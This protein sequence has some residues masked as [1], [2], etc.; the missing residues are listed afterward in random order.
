MVLIYQRPHAILALQLQNIKSIVRKDGP[1]LNGKNL[2]LERS[3]YGEFGPGTKRIKLVLTEYRVFTWIFL[4]DTAFVIFNN[5]PPRMVIKEMRMHMA[6][7]ETCF[8]AMTA[9]QCHQQIQFSLPT[10][11]LYWK[12]SFRGAFEFLCKDDLSLEMRH[13]VS[14]LG[15]LV[16]FALASGEFHKPTMIIPTNS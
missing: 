4:L 7:P 15:P 2:Q 12:V 6:M 11:S 10:Q 8:Q 13:T 16:L 5:L 9:D 1:S 14:S 3:L